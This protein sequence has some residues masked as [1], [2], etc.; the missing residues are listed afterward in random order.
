LFFLKSTA[1]LNGFAAATADVR[2]KRAGIPVFIAWHFDSTIYRGRSPEKNDQSALR[3]PA[4]PDN[5]IFRRRRRYTDV[6]V[7]PDVKRQ[8]ATDAAPWRVSLVFENS[9]HLQ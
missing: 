1:F 2:R 7:K 5:Q 8:G 3:S 6:P 9:H 4:E